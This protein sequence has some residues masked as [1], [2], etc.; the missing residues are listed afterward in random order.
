MTPMKLYRLVRLV[1]GWF[2]RS[3]QK[4]SVKNKSLLEAILEVGSVS[5]SMFIGWFGWCRLVQ[6][7]AN[8]SKSLLEATLEVGS[9]EVGLRQ[10]VSLVTY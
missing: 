3:A 1:R 5:S 8:P 10:M 4:E 9:Q 7:V 2:G 6:N